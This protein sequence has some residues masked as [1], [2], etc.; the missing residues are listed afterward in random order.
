MTVLFLSDATKSH[1]RDYLAKEKNTIGV[2][3][4]VKSGS[5]CSGLRYEVKAIDSIVEGDIKV[6]SDPLCFVAKNSLFAL[7]GMKVD[8]K[9]DNF[10]SELVY[11]NPKAKDVCGCGESFKVK[12]D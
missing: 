2:R 12:D 7:E 1:L 8:L 11:V 5:G 6:C 4:S 3:F 9:K 10:G